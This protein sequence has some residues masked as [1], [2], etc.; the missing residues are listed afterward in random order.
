MP[1]ALL[2]SRANKI[3]I[4]KTLYRKVLHFRGRVACQEDF[5]FRALRRRANFKGFNRGEG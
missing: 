3:A 2:A 1:T 5:I 4:K